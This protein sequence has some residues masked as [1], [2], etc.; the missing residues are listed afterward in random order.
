MT[1]KKQR[2]EMLDYVYE[3]LKS[4]SDNVKPLKKEVLPGIETSFVLVGEKG[5]VVMVDQP[6]PQPSMDRICSSASSQR[7]DAVFILL[8]D[9][10][11]FFRNAAERNYFKKSK[12]LSLKGYTDQQM[13]Q[14]ILFRPEEILLGSRRQVLQY[15]QPS[16]E[17]LEQ[18]IVSFRFQPVVFDYSHINSN[19]R[20]RPADRQSE[21][22]HIWTGKG[23]VKGDLKVDRGYLVPR[24]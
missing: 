23:E 21:R 8:K 1:S 11:T 3:K 14:M 10:I 7:P 9:G 15:Y 6:Y 2:Q 12:G 20:F 18:A 24:E 22:L 16:S 19:A 17:R 13:H 5:I 4:S